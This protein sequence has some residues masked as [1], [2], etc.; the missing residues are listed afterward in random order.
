MQLAEA[1]C[2]QGLALAPND[3]AA[4]QLLGRIAHE[5]GNH[6]VAIECFERTVRLDPGNPAAHNNLGILLKNQGRLLEAMACYQHALRLKPDFVQACNNLGN[7]WQQLGK[8]D[9][10]IASCRRAIEINPNFPDPYVTLGNIYREQDRWDEA[11][12]I[13]EQALA[14]NQNLAAAHYGLAHILKDR[15]QLDAAIARYHRATKLKPDV[16][17]YHSSLVYALNFHAG[18]DAHSILEEHRRWNQLHAEPLSRFIEP[19]VNDR[20][21]DRRLRVGYVS[22]D[23]RSHSVGRF[24][25]PLLQA[26]DHDRLEVFCYSSVRKPDAFT[27]SCQASA[28]TWRD[29]LACSD[30]ELAQTIRKDQIDI[31]VDLTMHTADSRLLVFARKPAPVQVTYLAYCGTTGL[32]AIDYRITDVYLDPPGHDTSIYSEQSVR[33]PEAY[34]CYRPM[35]EAPEVSSLPAAR[36]GMVTFGSM[37]NFCKVTQPTLAA[38]SRLLQVIPQSR[39]ILHMRQGAHREE[40]LRSFEQQGIA[41]QRLV[42]MDWLNIAEY[43]KNYAQVDIALD[44]FPHGGGTTTCDA[45]WMG[46]PV[47]SLAGQMAVSRGSLS[48]LSNLGLADLVAFDV[49]RYIQIAANLAADLPRLGELRSSLRG[50]MQKSPLMDEPRFARHIEA[51]YREMWHRWCVR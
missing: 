11:V 30:E 14:L 1:T 9:E 27:A 49:D 26:H 2:R 5:T 28:D 4:W 36:N 15:G 20:S 43:F 35:A 51:A 25:L 31:L 8:L 47:V 39:L 33:L 32:S 50:R 42:L 40:L 45:L 10:A 19:H 13:Y 34:W 3:P 24:I 37:N 6:A 44:P 23:F 41:R 22:P 12:A 46:V 29:V 16:A 7:V 21:P 18:I 38:W 48:I 17:R